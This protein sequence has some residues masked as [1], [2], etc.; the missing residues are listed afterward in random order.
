MLEIII[1]VAGD[2]GLNDQV[3][4]LPGLLAVH[5]LSDREALADHIEDV[6]WTIAARPSP[7]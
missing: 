5:L 2:I 6:P 7:F 1:A 4:A 3:G